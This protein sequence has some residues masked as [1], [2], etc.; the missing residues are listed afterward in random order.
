MQRTILL[1]SVLLS[2]TTIVSAFLIGGRYTTA[3]MRAAKDNEF[4][5]LVVVDRFTGA[6][7]NCGTDHCRP[8]K[9]EEYWAPAGR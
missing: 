9:L 6:T 7:I 8:T 3:V 5:Y 4:S 1:A 2:A